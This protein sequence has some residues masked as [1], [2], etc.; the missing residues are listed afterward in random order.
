MLVI[1]KC[2]LSFW[3]VVCHF[4]ELL[5]C[6]QPGPAQSSLARPGQNIPKFLRFFEI[7]WDFWDFLR[8]SEIFEIFE[9]FWDFLRLFEIFEI[10]WDFLRFVKFLRFLSLLDC[11]GL[12]FLRS[13]TCHFE[14]LL[15]ILKCCLSF[16]S[17]AYHF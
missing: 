3:I 15:V 2:C 13:V 7:F 16:L 17:V 5:Y 1:L 10:F 6:P 14:V 11:W 8:F 12:R 9:I 4:K